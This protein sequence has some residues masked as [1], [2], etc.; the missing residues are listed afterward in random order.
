[1]SR[2]RLAP[3]VLIAAILCF[4]GCNFY[5]NKGKIEG[6]K[7]ESEKATIDGKEFEEGAFYLEFEKGG[8]LIY[9][10]V[11]STEEGKYTIGSGEQVTFTFEKEVAGSKS[12]VEKITVAGDRLT[13]SDA[14]GTITFTRIREDKF[15]GSTWVSGPVKLKDKAGDIHDREFR[16]DFQKD[17]S[18][19]FDGRK[20]GTF[21]QG[22]GTLTL[23]FTEK[24]GD[25][26]WTSKDM[27]VADDYS[28]FT[29]ATVD[30]E[31]VKFKR[32]Y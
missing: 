12:H 4:A 25:V 24:A 27:P 22:K 18:V 30:G 26:D 14:K 1:M 10:P 6:T 7:W 8:K 23:N 17:G 21:V 2:C 19:N 20:V 31:K 9:G 29:M 16:F 32:I 15:E 11:G 5:S 3:L 13:M 28:H